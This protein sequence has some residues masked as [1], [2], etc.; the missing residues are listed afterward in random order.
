MFYRRQLAAPRSALRL[1]IDPISNAVAISA[2]NPAYPPK[3]PNTTLQTPDTWGAALTEGVLADD[4]LW[5]IVHELT[6]H[7]SLNTPVGT[8]L[9]ALAVS[10]TSVLGVQSG[11]NSVAWI[12]KDAV[13]HALMERLL[14]PILEGLALFAEFDAISRDAPIATWS[15]QTAAVLFSKR[16]MYAAMTRG[17]DCLCP[18]TRKLESLRVS[19]PIVRRKKEL[20][21]RSLADN[22]G[23][24]LGYLLIKMIWNDLV[25]RSR[26]F[27]H[28]D[29]FLAFLNNYFFDDFRLAELLVPMSPQEH[30]DDLDML[31]IYLHNRLV[32]L[33]RNCTSYIQEFLLWMEDPRKPRPNYQGHSAAIEDR[34]KLCWTARTLR[35]LHWHTPDFIATRNIP[36]ILVAPAKVTIATG[37]SFEARFDDGSPPLTGPA[38]DAAR[39]TNRGETVGD[40]SVEAL[41]LL[42]D[43]TRVVAGLILC[44]FLDKDL[45][46]TFNPMTGAFN[47]PDMAQA[48]DKMASFLALESFCKMVESE[49]ILADGSET[50]RLV[51]ELRGCEGL[52]KTLDLWLPF[53]LIPEL[54]QPHR[55]RSL[56][57]FVSAGLKRTLCV[58]DSQMRLL[59]AASL[60]PMN[61]QAQ[62]DSPITAQDAQDIA[63]INSTS[64]E[65]LGFSLLNI[66][67]QTL[68]PSRI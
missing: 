66:K 53:A 14:R 6:H 32:L 60:T 45:V 68:L 16:E 54:T 27:S 41:L 64:R 26:M 5:P 2:A 58:A 22:E 44:V 34:L 18:I 29:T 24:L 23:Y 25:A 12:A 31:P 43:K 40:G 56:D 50:Q 39:P 48:C 3:Q 55:P 35:H 1:A 47:E 59:S 46:A 30:D 63:A 51:D 42:P 49:R 19:A 17:E 62:L 4:L 8:S 21:C 37:G 20:L 67:D 57:L 15:M 28:S 10:H 65:L 36:R 9:S 38:L 13:R 52:R 7:S 11:K 33:S 61:S